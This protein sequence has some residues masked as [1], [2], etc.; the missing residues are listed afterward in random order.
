[1]TVI[2]YNTRILCECLTPAAERRL[3]SDNLVAA[4]ATDY[5]PVDNDCDIDNVFIYPH[6]YVGELNDD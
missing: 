3:L 6:R 1:M 5:L 4:A 2:Y